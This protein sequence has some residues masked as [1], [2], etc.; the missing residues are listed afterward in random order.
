MRFRPQIVH[1]S[2]HGSLSK[3]IV[4]EDEIGHS[5]T[6]TSQAIERIFS[7]F[8]DDVKPVFPSMPVSPSVRQRH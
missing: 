2:G 5:N 4:L 3:D 8:R 7:V 6:L 1:F